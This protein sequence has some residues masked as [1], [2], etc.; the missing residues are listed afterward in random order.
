MQSADQQMTERICLQNEAATAILI[1][2]NEA[3]CFP[4]ERMEIGKI[5]GPN[6]SHGRQKGAFRPD[7]PH[8]FGHNENC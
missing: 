8:C 2:A 4:S 1:L 6:P 3:F 7:R 5:Y